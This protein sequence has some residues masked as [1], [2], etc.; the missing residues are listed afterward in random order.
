MTEQNTPRPFNPHAV[1]A[2]QYAL[3]AAILDDDESAARLIAAILRDTGMHGVRDA[4]VTCCETFQHHTGFPAGTQ[5]DQTYVHPE[6]GEPIPESEAEP[7]LV[8]ASHVIEAYVARD[9]ERFETLFR[10]LGDD[11]EPVLAHLT[12]MVE[13]VAAQVMLADQTRRA[14]LS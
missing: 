3:N 11:P 14:A 12:E 2:A 10:N 8:W 7:T 5:L 9:Q 13:H 4:I 6:T 1:A